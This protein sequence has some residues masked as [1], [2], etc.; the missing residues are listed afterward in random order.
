MLYVNIIH[1]I[2]CELI[3]V[4]MK[5]YITKNNVILPE[6]AVIKVKAIE[7]C[8]NFFTRPICFVNFI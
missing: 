7:L 6:T 2:I 8:A 5:K 3:S 1:V 4:I